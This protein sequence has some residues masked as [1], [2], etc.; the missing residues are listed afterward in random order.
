MREAYGAALKN[1]EEIQKA[2]ALAALGVVNHSEARKNAATGSLDSMSG[3]SNQGT[4]RKRK[5]SL[6]TPTTP[7]SPMSSSVSP[8]RKRCYGRRAK[9][10]SHLPEVRLGDGEAVVDPCWNNPLSSELAVERE[11]GLS[12]ELKSPMSGET[13]KPEPDSFETEQSIGPV[14]KC[15]LVFSRL[16]SNDCPMDEGQNEG[17]KQTAT[18]PANLS[19]R[20]DQT[21]TFQLRHSAANQP[22]TTNNVHPLIIEGSA[23]PRPKSTSLIYLN[24]SLNVDDEPSL[25]HVPYFGEREVGDGRKEQI[26][27]A[28]DDLALF[29]TSERNHMSTYGPKFEEDENLEVILTVIRSLESANITGGIRKYMEFLRQ[30]YCVLSELTGV[31][32]DRIQNEHEKHIEGS[33]SGPRRILTGDVARNAQA[34]LELDSSS[35]SSSDSDALIHSS[36]RIQQ[37]QI[38]GKEF[39]L[40]VNSMKKGDETTSYEECLDSYRN[41]FCRRCF[42]YDCNVHGVNSTL[43]DVAMQGELALLK[44]GEGH[45]DE[46][47]FLSSCFM[48]ISAV[49]YLCFIL[50]I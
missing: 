13:T 43:A 24:S 40:T 12:E 33:S 18:R 50:C 49:S 23:P 14:N 46:V 11:R 21:F 32:V 3:C 28:P 31:P 1:Q 5:R 26:A 29:D 41:L 7:T 10:R 17:P 16:P 38:Q 27:L 36:Q 15:A 35:S 6:P 25:S 9:Q 4:P 42:T 39:N 47:G 2:I 34:A 22:R 19:A 30:V 48:V 45:W 44:E 37:H 20:S 8:K